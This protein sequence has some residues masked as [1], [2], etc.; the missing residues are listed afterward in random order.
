M[1]RPEGNLEYGEG[2]LTPS[3]IE[4]IRLIFNVHQAD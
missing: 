2:A 1:V 4:D 3:Q